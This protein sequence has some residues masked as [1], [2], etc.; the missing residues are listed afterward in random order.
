MNN[1][2]QVAVFDRVEAKY[3]EA[4][5]ANLV[6]IAINS[7]GES[8]AAVARRGVTF[9]AHSFSISEKG[10]AMLYWGHYDMTREQAEKIMRE[11]ARF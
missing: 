5:S 4:L 1:S 9:V 11:K 8:G 3:T 10:H 6:S 2:N 7:D